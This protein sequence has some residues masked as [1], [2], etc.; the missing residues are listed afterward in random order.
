M[1]YESLS[2][3]AYGD[4]NQ[5]IKYSTAGNSPQRESCPFGQ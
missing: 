2:G 4:D 1:D 5:A 3:M